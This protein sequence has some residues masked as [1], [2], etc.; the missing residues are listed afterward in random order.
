MVGI[1]SVPKP[2]E[3]KTEKSP[4]KTLQLLKLFFFCSWH[5]SK[6][7]NSF[8]CYFIMTLSFSGCGFET[9]C[10]APEQQIFERS[11]E[12]RTRWRP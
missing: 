2:G 12:A 4:E 5:I 3:Q 10:R 7:A 11:N 6:A 1:N 8:L 9:G